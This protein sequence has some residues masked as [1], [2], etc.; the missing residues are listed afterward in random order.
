MR[1][2]TE[3]EGQSNRASLALWKEI[4][5]EVRASARRAMS[6]ATR[7]MPTAERAKLKRFLKNIVS[8]HD[9]G[10]AARRARVS[11]PLLERWMQTPGV[12]WCIN[13]AW[14]TSLAHLFADNDAQLILF[15]SKIAPELA[16]DAETFR[17]TGQRNRES[18]IV[19]K[20]VAT[21][22]KAYPWVI[23]QAAINDDRGFFLDLA[24]C[25]SG[26]IDTALYDQLDSDIATL[27]CQQPGISAKAA[28]RALETKGHK[29]NEEMFRMRKQRLMLSRKQ[30]CKT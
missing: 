8:L 30:D 3:I 15:R 5:A 1:R 10:K 27:C 26:K 29:L 11:R 16:R 21:N 22:L 24:K 25:L 2:S 28:V 23:A 4:E 17:A 20:M 9:V 6:K 12:S 18:R 14:N 19:A 7:G 13:D